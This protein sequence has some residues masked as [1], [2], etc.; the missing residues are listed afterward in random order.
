MGLLRQA[1]KTVGTI[2]ELS[3]KVEAARV[4]VVAAQ[5][6]HAAASDD[7]DRAE[8]SA[9]NS[10]ADF[11]VHRA[12]KRL[13]SAADRVDQ[14]RTEWGWL[15][16]KLAQANRAL[17]REARARTREALKEP[18]RAQLREV[19]A[20]A[21]ALKE[22]VDAANATRR[23]IFDTADSLRLFSGFGRVSGVEA[24]GALEPFVK[25]LDSRDHG[26]G[27]NSALDRLNAVLTDG[28]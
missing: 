11:G 4:A 8:D 21:R 6:E 3:E 7:L 1:E 20:R 17:D 28:F 27:P 10:G 19:A 25:F 22:A 2:E 24:I 9:D 13:A 16:E 5:A 23:K 18:Y 12:R 26:C 14:L 15:S